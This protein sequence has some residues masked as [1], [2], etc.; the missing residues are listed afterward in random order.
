MRKA[1]GDKDAEEFL[2]E[3]TAERLDPPERVELYVSMRNF[4]KRLRRCKGGLCAGWRE[5]LRHR[6]GVVKCVG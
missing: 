1:A 6:G 2:A 5:V 3:L 4:L